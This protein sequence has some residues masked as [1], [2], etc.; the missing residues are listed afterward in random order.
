LERRDEISNIDGRNTFK[1]IKVG[2]RNDDLMRVLRTNKRTEKIMTNRNLN[3][4]KD[5]SKE[6][7]WLDWKFSFVL[8]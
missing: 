7:S 6:R 1:N 2:L 3:S 4:F 8:F 5:Y